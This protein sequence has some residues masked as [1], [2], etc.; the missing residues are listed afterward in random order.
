[1]ISYRSLST[2]VDLSTV[3]LTARSTLP[4][5]MD[6]HLPIIVC[7]SIVVMAGAVHL[8]QPV[9]MFLHRDICNL[10]KPVY[11]NMLVRCTAPEL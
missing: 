7:L 5:I 9:N 11:S 6:Y 8:N 10:N 3:G 4:D 2:V 1:M